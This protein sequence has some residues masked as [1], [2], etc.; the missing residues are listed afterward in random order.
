[1]QAASQIEA[2]YSIVFKA[3]DAGFNIE[4]KTHLISRKALG[5]LERSMEDG[6]ELLRRDQVLKD[7]NVRPGQQN[8][9]LDSLPMPLIVFWQSVQKHIFGSA[10]RLRQACLRRLRL[11]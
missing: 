2:V 7:Q 10:V 3:I 9:D 8:I 1:M 11:C 4:S 6:K 5:Y